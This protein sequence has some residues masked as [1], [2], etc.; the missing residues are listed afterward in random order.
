MARKFLDLTFTPSVVETQLQFGHGQGQRLAEN[1]ALRELELEDDVLSGAEAEFIQARD[2]F[3][4]ATVNEDDWP[5]VQHR[6][7][8]TGF[9]KVL[10]EKTLAYADYRGNQQMLSMGNLQGNTRTS[11]FFMDY[12]NQ[13]RLKILAHSEYVD[14]REATGTIA[15]LLKSVTDADYPAHIE[16]IVLFHVVAYDWNCPQHITPRYTRSEWRAA[17]DL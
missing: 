8:P 16:R 5:Y 13:R 2:S 4:M 15:E 6:G 3:Y 9:L 7:G 12:A 10:D 14:A 11:L 1:K 17:T